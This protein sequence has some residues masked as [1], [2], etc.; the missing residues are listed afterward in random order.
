M[1]FLEKRP[2]FQPYTRFLNTFSGKIHPFSRDIRKN[3]NFCIS[4]KIGDIKN[5]I[6]IKNHNKDSKADNRPKAG[7]DTYF[8]KKRPTLLFW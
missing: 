3:H 5:N 7:E 8:N 6:S 4:A 1:H 2:I